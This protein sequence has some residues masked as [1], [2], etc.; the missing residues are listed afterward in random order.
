MT[1]YVEAPTSP[2]VKLSTYEEYMSTALEAV[3][4]CASSEIEFHARLIAQNDCNRK[5]RIQVLVEESG[6]NDSDNIPL[7][8]WPIRIGWTRAGEQFG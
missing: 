5:Y 3:N 8:S 2:R 6:Y 7:K 1:G 4:P